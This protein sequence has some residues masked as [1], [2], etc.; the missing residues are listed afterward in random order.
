MMTMFSYL[1]GLCLNI[2]KLLTR[3]IKGSVS[4]TTLFHA[5]AVEKSVVRPSD[6]FLQLCSGRVDDLRSRLAQNHRL[7]PE[8]RP[9]RGRHDQNTTKAKHASDRENY[10]LLT[11]RHYVCH[12]DERSHSNQWI[13]TRLRATAIFL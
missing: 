4:Q 1:G 12:G 11:A 3:E 5:L 7:N 13:S 8:L 10:F 9:H 6:E 2:I